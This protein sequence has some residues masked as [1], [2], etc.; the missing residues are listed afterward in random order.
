MA[1]VLLIE[2]D[3]FQAFLAALQ[4]EG[5]GHE[6]VGVTDNVREAMDMA[7]KMPPDVV[8]MELMLNGEMDGVD[9]GNKLHKAYG[10]RLVYT[11]TYHMLLNSL[12]GKSATLAKPYMPEELQNIIEEIMQGS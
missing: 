10:C 12:E 6:I 5:M 8:V 11:S 7:K 9:L 4:I 3:A 2:G 1:R